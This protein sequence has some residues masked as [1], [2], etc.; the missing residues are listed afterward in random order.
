MRADAH[1]VD[2]LVAPVTRRAADDD[3]RPLS[4]TPKIAAASAAQSRSDSSL[5]NEDELAKSL[6]AVL[7]CT[8]L[9]ADGMPRLTR[10]V[11]VDMIR[12]EA[13]RTI[14]ALR[15]AHMVRHGVPPERRLTDPRRILDRIVETVRPET[16]LRGIRMTTGADVADAVKVR[17][18]EN[19]LVAAMSSIVI[20]LAAGL[21]DVQG[22][23][24]DLSVTATAS[25]PVTFTV[26]QESV[27]LPDTYL[28]VVTVTGEPSSTPE[29]TP[30]VAL[31]LVAEAYG[32]N[33]AVTRLPHGT[34]VAVELPADGF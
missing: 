25:G 29:T 26:S 6:S 17:G 21:H 30:L 24:L 13:Q 5:L 18:D 31:R 32:G 10:A 8:D 1:Y 15:A 12:A 33:V 23:K 11:A 22:A 28:K 34:Q 27:I 3:A 4:A 9:M 2:Q 7:S 16:R 20:M 14:S 19:C